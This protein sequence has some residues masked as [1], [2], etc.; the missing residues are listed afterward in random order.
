MSILHDKLPCSNSY[1]RMRTSFRQKNGLPLHGGQTTAQI[2]SPALIQ[3]RSN[4]DRA[5]GLAKKNFEQMLDSDDEDEL[6]DNTTRA[7]GPAIGIST[8]D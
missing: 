7:A 4:A 5:G 1:F 2:A 3:K 6:E 8:L